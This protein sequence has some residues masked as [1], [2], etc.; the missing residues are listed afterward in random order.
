MQT[1][2]LSNSSNEGPPGPPLPSVA[3]PKAT[4][5]KASELKCEWSADEEEHLI[6]FLLTCGAA[7]ADGGNFKPV[8]W[9]AAVVEMAKVPTKGPNK[10]VKACASKYGRC[11]DLAFR[12][13]NRSKG[14]FFISLVISFIIS[15]TRRFTSLLNPRVCFTLR[16][17]TFFLPG[18]I[19]KILIHVSYIY[20]A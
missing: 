3:D 20:L 9:N 11:Y 17:L 18:V 7:A 4:S 1:R 5:K 14:I 13:Y 2:S 10:T 6:Q 8:T 19:C 12:G 15:F 16:R